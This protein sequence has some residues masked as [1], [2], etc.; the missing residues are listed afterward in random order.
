M[1]IIKKAIKCIGVI[2][3]S[4]NGAYG[5]SVPAAKDTVTV[6]NNEFYAGLNISTMGM[7]ATLTKNITRR[8]DVKLNASNLG[9]SYDI[10]KLKSELMGDAP[11]KVGA[12]G[13]GVDYY[14]WRFLY[15]SGGLTYN[16]THV[17]I[18]AQKA[19]SIN[20]GDIVLE[21]GDIGTMIAEITPGT[22]FN[23]YL[24]GG[25]NFRR[26]KSL[27]FGIEFGLFFTGAPH[28]KLQATGMLEPSASPEQQ[29]IIEQNI[30][31]LIYYPNISLRL[32]YRIKL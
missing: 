1:F 3:I 21:P 28:V 9:Y 14:V 12:I 8:L 19:E 22:R 11:L 16:L 30:S 26:D 25:L 13:I 27:N 2:L 24:G 31:P 29:Q 18:H 5:H 6:W 32:S 20:V 15:F 17:T 4:L 10:N 23:P 7:G